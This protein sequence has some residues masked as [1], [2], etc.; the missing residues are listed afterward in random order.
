MDN[1]LYN[2]VKVLAEKGEAADVYARYLADTAD[3]KECSRLFTRL[4]AQD[5]KDIEEIKTML[6]SHI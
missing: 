4:K 1:H 2:L 3:C 6:A 5:E